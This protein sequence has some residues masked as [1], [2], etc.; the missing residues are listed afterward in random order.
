[1]DEKLEYL[2][3]TGA[4]A[5][6][7]LH[8]FGF[9]LIYTTKSDL[10]NQ[11]LITLDLSLTEMIISW[12]M[13]IKVVLLLTKNKLFIKESDAWYVDAFLD[14]AL[15]TSIRL[16][17][18]HIIIDRFIDIKLNIKY[19]IYITEKRLKFIVLSM[20]IVSIISAVIWTVTKKLQ[21]LELS[22]WIICISA[23]IVVAD[24]LIVILSIVT[25]TYFFSRVTKFTQNHDQQNSTRT[26]L[27]IR[28]FKIPCL[29]VL[30]FIMFNVSGTVLRVCGIRDIPHVLDLLG[31]CSDSCIYIFLQRRIRQRLTK[32]FLKQ[33]S[34]AVMSTFR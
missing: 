3:L 17:V 11:R 6:A 9:C 28:K 29:M 30:T 10:P 8:T 24:T 13:V 5:A 1:M 20:W 16:V 26:S 7:F 18:L 22:T 33:A 25:Y 4:I 12:K 15:Y 19:P 21:I 34:I 27:I 23:V 31:W 32:M 2:R 14:I